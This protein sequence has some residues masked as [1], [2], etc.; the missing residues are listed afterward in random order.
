MGQEILAGCSSADTSNTNAPGLV[1]GANSAS[2]ANVLDFPAWRP[3]AMHH[4]T[5]GS[6][7]ALA[8]DAG[9]ERRKSRARCVL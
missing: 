6:G 3:L 8:P 1:K 5:G 4:R 7:A 2:M 9:L